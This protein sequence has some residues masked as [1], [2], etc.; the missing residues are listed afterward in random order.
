VSITF[1]G[2]YVFTIKLRNNDLFQTYSEPY[3]YTSGAK[4]LLD[5]IRE[6]L[7]DLDGLEQNVIKSPGDSMIQETPLKKMRLL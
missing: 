3:D 1:I 5:S 2:K 4:K 6:K 7:Q